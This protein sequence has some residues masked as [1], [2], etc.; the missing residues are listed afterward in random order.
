MTE[1][2]NLNSTPETDEAPPP[3]RNSAACRAAEIAQA[4]LVDLIT[5]GR[6]YF[7]A[8]NAGDFSEAEMNV[9]VS[10]DDHLSEL[11]ARRQPATP[12]EFAAKVHYLLGRIENGSMSD[13][14]DAAASASIMDDA[15]AFAAAPPAMEARA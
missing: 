12:E 11:I 1:A 2:E 14:M 4:P 5:C 13:A 6:V 10:F 9:L 7:A 15:A 3:H 8:I